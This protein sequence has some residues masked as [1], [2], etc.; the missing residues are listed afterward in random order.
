MKAGEADACGMSAR[1]DPVL[2]RITE[3]PE[4]RRNK[5]NEL[6]FLFAAPGPL[7]ICVSYWRCVIVV[8]VTGD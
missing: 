7:I 2:G 6:T 4:T 3:Q 8:S 1:P 5:M